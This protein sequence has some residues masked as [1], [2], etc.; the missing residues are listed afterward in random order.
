MK[1]IYILLILISVYSFGQT[2]QYTI[3]RHKFIF[4]EMQIDQGG[5]NQEVLNLY[6]GKEKLLSHIL[7]EE[8]VD[9]SSISIRLGNYYIE[10]N[11]IIFYSYWA[12]ADRMPL[13][14]KFGFQKQVYSVAQNGNVKLENSK[15]YIEDLIETQNK[16]FLVLN[17]WQHKGL[18][19]LNK[20][21]KN[22]QQKIWLNDYIY[23]IEKQYNAKFVL[24]KA[25]KELE[26]EVRCKMKEIIEFHTK[27]WNNKEAY[28]KSKR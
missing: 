7:F 22:K 24:G 10:K 4:K 3:N 16:D 11:K 18:K 23:N 28:G 5:Y 26:K 27:A 14:L 21:P 2:K 1:K 6:R 20:T 25:R 17:G 8:D 9:C 19:Y 12:S 13:F 15:I